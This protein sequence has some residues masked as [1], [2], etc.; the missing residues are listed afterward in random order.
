MRLG[1][2]RRLTNNALWNS[3]HRARGLE[4]AADAGGTGR[5]GP[6]R[7]GLVFVL[8]ISG[9]DA[10]TDFGAD[11]VRTGA[12]NSLDLIEIYRSKKY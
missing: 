1:T 12:L 3:H 6:C 9:A 5:K 4:G 8:K 7:R 10:R 2:L 11:G